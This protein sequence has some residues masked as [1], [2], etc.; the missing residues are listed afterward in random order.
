TSLFSSAFT[1]KTQGQY[2]GTI[3]FLI[4]L[5][6][7]Y[8][9]LA[10]YKSV[11]EHRWAAKS[12]ATVVVIAGKNDGEK[13][14][15]D[16]TV[17]KEEEVV[18]APSGG[19]KKTMPWRISTELPRACL[20]T[21]NTGIGYLLMLA[22]MTMNVGYFMAVLAGYFVGDLVFGRWIKGESH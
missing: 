12:K 3:I 4:V 6:I 14:G 10:A 18:P 15:L 5:A 22:V 11:L 9:G 17:T 16:K 21:V 1:P 2:A 13:E 19:E 7:V 8:R 20:G